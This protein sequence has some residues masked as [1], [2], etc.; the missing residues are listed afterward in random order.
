MFCDSFA[1]SIFD[2]KS[3]QQMSPTLAKNTNNLGLCKTD[4]C[5]K[6]KRLSVGWSKKTLQSPI[7]GCSFS[8]DH[9]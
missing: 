9:E 6:Y 2:T 4:F 5:R 7:Y 1:S 8:F 3:K